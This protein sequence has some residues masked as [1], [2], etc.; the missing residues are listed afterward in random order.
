MANKSHFNSGLKMLNMMRANGV[1]HSSS[2]K[3]SIPEKTRHALFISDA[4]DVLKKIPDNS[5][6]LILIDPPYNIDMEIGRA[7]W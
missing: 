1:S 5:I 7:S 6:Q 2:I 4:V 3:F